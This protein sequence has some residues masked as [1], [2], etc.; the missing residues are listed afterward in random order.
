MAGLR[1]GTENGVPYICAVDEVEGLYLHAG[2]YRNG[3]VLGPA[4]VQ[5]MTELVLGRETFCDD[6]PYK[7]AASH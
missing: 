5:L 2:H 6:S 1:P 4:S 3:I 7:V